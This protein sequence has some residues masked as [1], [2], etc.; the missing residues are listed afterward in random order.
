MCKS[1]RVALHGGTEN[2]NPC[3][4]SHVEGSLYHGRSGL[5]YNARQVQLLH[6]ADGRLEVLVPGNV[7]KAVVGAAHNALEEDEAKR[8]LKNLLV[9]LISLERFAQ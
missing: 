2:V 7:K 6:Q 8:R 4:Q 1:R 5:G 9:V 3:G